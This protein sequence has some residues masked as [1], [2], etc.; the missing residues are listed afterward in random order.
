MFLI[1]FF[2]WCRQAVI[3]R[4][5]LYNLG[6]WYEHYS[7]R[8]IF[9]FFVLRHWFSRLTYVRLGEFVSCIGIG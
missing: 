2:S 3:I 4:L 1:F 9:F 8:L 7:N 6:W 5:A